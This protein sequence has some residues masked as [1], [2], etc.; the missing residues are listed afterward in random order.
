MGPIGLLILKK[1][2]Y[3][4]QNRDSSYARAQ[5]MAKYVISMT[6]FWM[7][8]KTIL[9]GGKNCTPIF[10]AYLTHKEAIKKQ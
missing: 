4:Q 7:C 1:H 9:R 3:R 8:Y 5:V 6:A 10:V 2:G